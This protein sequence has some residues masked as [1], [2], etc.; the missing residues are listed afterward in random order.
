MIKK[1]DIVTSVILTI[2]TCGLYGIYWFVVL[3]DD[4]GRVTEDNSISGGVSVLLYF[5][6]CGLYGIYWAYKMGQKLYTYSEEN[7]KG[8]A[9]NSIA[10]LIIQ[11]IGFGIINYCLIQNDLNKLAESK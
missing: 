3:T 9:D 5:L 8:L 1:R 6:T 7:K 10:Y 4:V 11:L 2:V